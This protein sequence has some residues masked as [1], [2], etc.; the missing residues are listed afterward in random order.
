L[1]IMTLVHA[2]YVFGQEIIP[3]KTWRTHLSYRNV[4]DFV[5]DDRLTAATPSAIF[6]IENQEIFTLNKQ[7]G[8]SDVNITSLGTSNDFVIVGY[9][10]GNLDVLIDNEIINYPVI[11]DSDITGSKSINDIV[12]NN[13]E[14]FLLTDFGI[15]VFNPTD[16]S[17]VDSYLEIGKN[18]NPVSVFGG[19]VLRDSLFLATQEGVIAGLVDGSVNLKDFRNWLRFENSDG[20]PTSEAQHIASVGQKLY[21]AFDEIGLYE[22]EAG[23]WVLRPEL[24]GE[25]FNFLGPG[26]ND[27][28]LVTNENLWELSENDFRAISSSLSTS[29]Q[30][31]IKFDNQYLVASSTNGIV[32]IEEETERAVFPGG[33]FSDENFRIF[34]NPLTIVSGGF[35]PENRPLENSKGFYEF[36]SG[37]WNSYSSENAAEITPIPEFKDITGFAH[38][39]N[40]IRYYSSF[41]YGLLEIVDG[42]VTTLID[43]NTSGSLLEN[44][45][46]GERGVLISAI[47]STDNGIWILNYGAQQPYK[48]LSQDGAWL[49]YGFP[50]GNTNFPTDI[51]IA[52]DGNIWIILSHA[53]GGG[54]LVFN[55]EATSFVVLTDTPGQGNLPSNLV[56]SIRFDKEGQAWVATKEGVAFFPFTGSVLTDREVDAVVP[57]FESRLLFDGEDVAAIEIDG[58]NR[59]W[60]VT[61]STLWLFDRNINNIL[62]RFDPDNSPLFDTDIKSLKIDTTGELFI[63]TSAGI[64]SYQSDAS[65]GNPTHEPSI[66]IYPNPVHVRDFNGVV[67]IKGVA[68]DA[69]VKITD[70]SGRLVW[71]S[72]A[73]GGTLSWDLRDLRGQI[74]QTGIYL[75]LS[76]NSEGSDTKIGKLALV[77]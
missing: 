72:Q 4:I 16:G 60:M 58:G 49:E 2:T 69:I 62:E 45:S 17:I 38:L 26:D 39:S 59:K 29:A 37:N 68:D 55:Q 76:A 15:V 65:E 52:P 12:E 27:L 57:V 64:L 66:S 56:N 10:N 30:K 67:T 20:I 18:G 32:I 42:G 19:T 24:L 41:G 11:R 43:E 33:P 54:I 13:G 36:T 74:P 77:N 31:I 3:T 23:L 50:G 35:D 6:Q 34:N 8:L 9:R 28:L 51:E 75:I 73:N 22:Y 21:T 1:L 47:A 53:T 14:V 25:T 63:G 40:G 5:Q 7:N 61:G 46:P 71:Q 70:L 44:I 48:F